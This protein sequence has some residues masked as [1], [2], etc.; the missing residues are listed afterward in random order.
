MF[1]SAISRTRC[2]SPA[3]AA[4]QWICWSDVTKIIVPFCGPSA[5]KGNA[6]PHGLS[7]V[8]YGFVRCPTSQQN[9]ECP[10]CPVILDIDTALVTPDSS[11]VRYEG[12][13]P[14]SHRKLFR[15]IVQSLLISKLDYLNSL[16]AGLPLRA[17]RPLQLVQNAAARLV[18]NLLKFT[19]I[20]PL[21][22]SLHWLPVAARIRFKT[23]MLAYK[24]KNGPAPP[25]MRSMVKADPYLKYFKPQ[26]QL[27]LKHHTSSLME[28][29]HG[30]Y[31]LSCSQMV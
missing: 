22:R 31:S 1:L 28:D 10:A 12:F 13:G 26:V 8:I 2:S 20:T 18:F 25:Y 16:L 6:K 29:K 5:S 27:G 19:N 17:I 11:F 24:A 15:V 30:D 14:F 3:P 9:T 21:L 7:P 23:L 4:R